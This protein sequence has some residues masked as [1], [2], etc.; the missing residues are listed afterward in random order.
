MTPQQLKPTFCREVTNKLTEAVR[1]PRTP[2]HASKVPVLPTRDPN[3]AAQLTR[4]TIIWKS[5]QV[6]LG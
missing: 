5:D 6:P 3:C 1:R 4:S 2:A